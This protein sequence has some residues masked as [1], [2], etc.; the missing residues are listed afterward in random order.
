MCTFPVSSAFRRY[1]WKLA[2]AFKGFKLQHTTRLEAQHSTWQQNI[3]QVDAS[4]RASVTYT[5]VING[6]DPACKLV[7]SA[8]HV[9]HW[10]ALLG[11][12]VRTF[13]SPPSPT[14]LLPLSHSSVLKQTKIKITVWHK[15]HNCWLDQN[16]R[17]KTWWIRS[18]FPPPPTQ[19][20]R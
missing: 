1:Y 12:N 14:S 10:Q 18:A 7:I 2:G 20:L 9:R 15:S 13:S 4:L 6:T 8:A 17:A 19:Q 16:V 3:S 11:K 5:L